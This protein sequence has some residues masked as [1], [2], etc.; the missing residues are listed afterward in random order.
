MNMTE[1]R[2]AFK[3]YKILAVSG[4][5]VVLLNSKNGLVLSSAEKSGEEVIVGKSKKFL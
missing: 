5:H 3:D 1:L 4:N 2:A